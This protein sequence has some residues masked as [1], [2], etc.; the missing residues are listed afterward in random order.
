MTLSLQL[1]NF[2]LILS[3]RNDSDL[4]ILSSLRLNYPFKY[5]IDW[6][7]MVAER[8][9]KLR[10]GFWTRNFVKKSQIKE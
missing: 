4:Y 3:L 9:N 8:N 10:V 2:G 7:S 6:L 5:S 1:I